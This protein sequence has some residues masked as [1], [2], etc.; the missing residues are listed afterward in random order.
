MQQVRALH[1]SDGRP[2]NA[3][4][5]GSA[6]GRKGLLAACYSSPGPRLGSTRLMTAWRRGCDEDRRAAVLLMLGICVCE[7]VSKYLSFHGRLVKGRE[8]LGWQDRRWLMVDVCLC[9][10]VKDWPI[11]FTC[12]SR[13]RSSGWWCP[14]SSNITAPSSTSTF[15]TARIFT[16]SPNWPARSHQSWVCVRVAGRYGEF[17]RVHR[18]DHSDPKEAKSQVQLS[19]HDN[20]IINTHVHTPTCCMSVEMHPCWAY[21]FH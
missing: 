6:S 14:A 18:S 12:A 7:C 10:R 15:S 2:S 16:V 11:R 3:V 4:C 8:C 1:Q 9:E 21:L 13:V 20:A 17:Y 19:L 5:L